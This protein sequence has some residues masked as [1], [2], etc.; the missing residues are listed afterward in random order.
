MKYSVPFILFFMAIWLTAVACSP[1]QPD[2]P[3]GGQP[4][5]SIYEEFGYNHLHGLGYDA[6]NERLLL[7]SHFGLFALTDDGLYQLG[8]SR[9]DLMGFSAHPDDPAV[10]Y[11]SGHPQGGGNLGVIRSEDGGQSW[12]QIFSGLEGET[13]DFH[14]MTV[15][16][17]DPQRLYGAF[18]G[19]LYVT[20]DG[21]DSWQAAA[22]EGLPWQAG[23]CW[24][25][26]CLTA[27]PAD[28][29]LVYA[30]TAEGLYHSQDGGESWSLLSDT[31]G[32]V[33]SLA[34]DPQN[35]RRLLAHT[36][37]DGIALSEDGGQSWQPR[38]EGI[39]LNEAE[40]AFV[41]TFHPRNPQILFLA[42]VGNQV[43]GS[44]DGGQTWQQLMEGMR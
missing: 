22:A 42:T 10:L 17:A 32:A 14:A 38:H 5:A 26:P 3:V 8:P 37:R 29:D 35:N 30:G 18:Q 31:A 2:D 28:P 16:P 11:A 33:A 41:F 19:R 36:E 13:V 34:V 25:A 9:D 44:Q 24:G 1:S 15:S 43:Y 12:Q 6:D 20:R 27:D 39:Q 40:Y 4:V 7:A 23:F 21:G